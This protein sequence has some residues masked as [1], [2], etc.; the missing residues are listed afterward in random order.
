MA[1]PTIPP[2]Q[3]GFDW[4][5]LSSSVPGEERVPPFA[6]PQIAELLRINHHQ[7]TRQAR[8][9]IR[10][11]VQAMLHFKHGLLGTEHLLLGIL[12]TPDQQLTNVL[13]KNGLD[14]VQLHQAFEAAFVSAQVMRPPVIL[15]TPS[16][17]H[18]FQRA[19][20]EAS[21]QHV[22]VSPSHLLLSMSQEDHGMAQAFLKHWNITS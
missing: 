20:E 13:A 16:C 9:A 6:D 12:S 10:R 11:A 15:V 2:Y 3:T 17:K 7:T 14:R 5:L 21:K 1:E 8:I 19:V 18:T 22:P 4:H